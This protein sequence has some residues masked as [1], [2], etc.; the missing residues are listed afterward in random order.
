M[1]NVRH[2]AVQRIARIAGALGDLLPDVV[3]I[4]GAIAPLLH[5]D[6]PFGE[7]RPTKDT[8]AVVASTRYSDVEALH[9]NLRRRGFRQ[10]PTDRKHIHRWYSPQND[11]LDLVPAGSHPGGS[12]QIWDRIALETSE[13]VDLGLWRPVRHASAPCFLALKW[14]AYDDRGKEDPF[15]SHDLEDIFALLAARPSIAN[16]VRES[17][18]ELREF[19]MAAVSKLVSSANLEDLLAAHLNNAQDPQ[20]VAKRV[21]VRLHELSGVMDLPEEDGIT[22]PK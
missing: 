15:G 11:I 4:G 2:P 8:D 16:E 12:G 5:V 19:I 22:A 20:A 1:Q 17:Q 7:P 21:R 13:E 10:G 3:F 18:I 9:E 6:S 14:A